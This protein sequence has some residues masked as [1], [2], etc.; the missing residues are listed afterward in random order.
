MGKAAR[1]KAQRTEK[2]EHEPK[3]PSGRYM[4]ARERQEDRRRDRVAQRIAAELSAG[5]AASVINGRT[6]DLRG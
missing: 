1:I 3:R 4:S 2:F 5:V 6:R